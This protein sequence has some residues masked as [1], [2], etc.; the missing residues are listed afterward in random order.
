MGKMWRS[1]KNGSKRKKFGAQVNMAQ[2][3]KNVAHF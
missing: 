3:G 1:R 2:N